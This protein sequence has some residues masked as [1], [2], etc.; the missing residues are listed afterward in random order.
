M[1]KKIGPISFIIVFLFSCTRDLSILNFSAHWTSDIPF[2]LTHVNLELPHDNRIY[3]TD[4]VLV[5]SDESS[6]AVKIDFAEKAELALKQVLSAFLISNPDEIG[7]G[8]SLKIVVYTEK[9]PRHS[10]MSFPFGY[11]LHG[12]DSQV[13]AQWPREMKSRYY[14]QMVH[15][16]VHVVQ[17]LLGV[18]PEPERR[19]HEPDR[20][21]NE[22]L[23][24]TVSGGFFIPINMR[25]QYKDWTKDKEHVNP[26]SIHQWSDLPIPTNRVGEYYPMFGLAVKYLIDPNGLGKSMSNVKAM[27]LTLAEQ[28]I[29]FARAFEQ[30]FGLSLSEYELTFYQRIDEFLK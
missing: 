23:A 22:G 18:M 24:E 3:E 16:T 4:H 27:L 29:T 9:I 15:E 21:F 25:Y 14:R 7:I 28:D 20:W 5:F 6:D 2:I 19:D 30:H 13:Y 1:K 8:S 26:I 17:F 10:Q 11:L 12:Q